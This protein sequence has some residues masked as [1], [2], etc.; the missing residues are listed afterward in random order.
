MKPYIGAQRLFCRTCLTIGIR[1]CA[2]CDTNFRRTGNRKYCLPCCREQQGLP[3][4]CVRNGCE[5]RLT[6]KDRKFCSSDCKLSCKPIK[7]QVSRPQDK[8]CALPECGD[9][10]TPMRSQQ[11]YCSKAHRRKLYKRTHPRTGRKR[12]K[13]PD[14]LRDKYQRRRARRRKTPLTR[15][16]VHL[17]DIAIRDDWQC[18]ICGQQVDSSLTTPHP[19]SKSIDHVIPLSLGGW[20]APWN[21]RLTHL[22]CNIRRSN[23]LSAADIAWLNPIVV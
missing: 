2:I 7:P 6:Y 23:H 1:A 19:L 16:P 15:H 22:S 18:G 10:F 8:L 3:S 4:I 11:Q 21:V 14:A 20:H 12:T 13:S 9:I 5:N 17:G